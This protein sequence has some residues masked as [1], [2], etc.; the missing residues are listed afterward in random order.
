MSSDL[1]EHLRSLLKQGQRLAAIRLYREATGASLA[2]ART[3]VV[4]LDK[5]L[6]REAVEQDFEHQLLELLEQHHKIQAIKLYREQTGA[7]LKQAKEAVEE[8]A[9]K[10]HLPTGASGCLGLI[11]LAF[12]VGLGAAGLAALL[13]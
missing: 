7:G 9:R 2:E 11:G 12:L 5:G 1:E 10:H 8:L 6:P 3:F 13:E 4:A